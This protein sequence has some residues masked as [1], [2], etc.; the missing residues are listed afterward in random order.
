V[1]K[2]VKLELSTLLA[3]VVPLND[4]E[5]AIT[6]AVLADVNRPLLSTVK[7]GMAVDEP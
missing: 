2:P 5:L 7:V 6:T 4:P 1:P 3:N